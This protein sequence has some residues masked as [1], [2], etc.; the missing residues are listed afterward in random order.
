[1]H[2]HE[3]RWVVKVDK[4][5]LSSVKL[6]SVSGWPKF[7][8]ALSKSKHNSNYHEGEVLLKRVYW[9]DH[10][11]Q[12]WGQWA[13]STISLCIPF[14]LFSH[15]SDVMKS[16]ACLLSQSSSNR[17]QS[18]S[19]P[20]AQPLLTLPSLLLPLLLSPLFLSSS[21][22]LFL[23]SCPLSFFLFG[24]PL[25]L[26]SLLQQGVDGGRQ[27]PYGALREPL[28]VDCREKGVSSTDAE[29]LRIKGNV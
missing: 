24:P 26:C 29:G 22:L 14:I 28:G 4:C 21:P 2:R 19:C 8:F 1:M 10:Q 3:G 23:L 5:Q 17:N 7:S 16:L 27:C 25:L 20:F 12:V 15:E 11:I 13:H 6:T 18:V 9:S